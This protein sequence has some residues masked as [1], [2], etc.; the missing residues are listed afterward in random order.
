MFTELT[1]NAEFYKFSKK[2][3]IYQWMNHPVVQ[4][5]LVKHGFT[6]AFFE[7]KFA[8]RVFDHTLSVL[9]G[10]NDVGRCP[11]IEAMLQIF[12]SKNIPL[13]DVFMICVHLKNAF[14]EDMLQQNILNAL[15]L[16][17]ICA[18]MDHNFQGVIQEYTRMNEPSNQPGDDV[19]LFE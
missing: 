9:K 6:V 4:H 14:L 16:R 13:S 8:S 17:E 12:K 3:I 7:E 18:L 2:F 19:V 15:S 1:K 10:E 11:V 5:T